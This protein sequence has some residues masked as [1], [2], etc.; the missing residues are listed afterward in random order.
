MPWQGK[1]MRDLRKAILEFKSQKVKEATEAL[2]QS[3]I[4]G[5]LAL[6]DLL[7]AAE[8]QTGIR[9][10]KQGGF[11]GRHRSGNMV[12]AVSHNAEKLTPTNTIGA[13]GWFPDQF[14]EYFRTQDQGST[15]P[16]P[17]ADRPGLFT[18][19]PAAMAMSGS[20]TVAREEF[21]RRLQAI[22]K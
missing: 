1:D 8:T 3:L 20:F 11:P 2:Q 9:R 5:A 19:V 6:Q 15:S 14:E 10:A 17:W 7:E 4:D 18:A 12:G 21:R 16:L 22:V 13:Y